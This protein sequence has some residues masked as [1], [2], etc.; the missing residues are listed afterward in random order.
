MVTIA[1]VAFTLGAIVGWI[2][3]AQS[4]VRANR[5]NDRG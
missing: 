3:G 2:R 5:A 1:I 4:Q